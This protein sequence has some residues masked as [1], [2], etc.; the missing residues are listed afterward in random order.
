MYDGYA[1]VRSKYFPK[2]IHVIDL[3]HV[4]SLLT[5]AISSVR[6]QVI[7]QRDADTYLDRF[8]KNHWET[9]M[10]R[11]EKIPDKYYSPQTDDG[12]I[13]HYQ[14]M[15]V[16]CIKLD[17][18]FWEGWNVLQDML[19]YKWYGTYDESLSFII[20][21]SERLKNT[22][23]DTLKKVGQ[24]YYK[25]RYE[26]ANGFVKNEYHVH[27]SNGIAECINNN[28]KTVIKLSYGYRNF[29]RFRKRCLLMYRY[30]K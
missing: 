17:Q 19:H 10:C 18:D 20:H 23:N 24:S 12:V 15:V 28:I 30:N 7:K 29:Q 22:G 16:E 3:F 4:I 26:I 9:F 27:I 5:N 6:C 14:E 1:Y 25:W 2:S 13:Y 8:M 21:M 11:Y